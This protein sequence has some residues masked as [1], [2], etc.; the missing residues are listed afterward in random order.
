MM[1]TLKLLFNKR[2][3][4]LLRENSVFNQDTSSRSELITDYLR[5]KY[6]LSEH[7]LYCP[8]SKEKYI[9]EIDST[10]LENVTFSVDTP[11]PKEYKERIFNLTKDENL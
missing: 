6:H 1:V 3:A 10:N 4:I 2:N 7:L 8:I 5:M 9:F 11:L